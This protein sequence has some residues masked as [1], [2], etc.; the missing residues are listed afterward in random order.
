MSRFYIDYNHNAIYYTPAETRFIDTFG[1]TIGDI[2]RFYRVNMNGEN[3][4]LIYDQ[5]DGIK[6][7]VPPLDYDSGVPDGVFSSW[8][9]SSAN[10][11]VFGVVEGR[12]YLCGAGRDEYGFRTDG[13]LSRIFSIKTDGTDFKKIT[14]DTKFLPSDS[15]DGMAPHF[16]SC[17]I[18]NNK[19]YVIEGLKLYSMNLDGTGKKKLC[20]D[21]LPSGFYIIGDRLIYETCTLDFYDKNSYSLGSDWRSYAI[22]LDGTGRKLLF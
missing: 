1:G 14:A 4:T 7:T 20:D 11:G 21:D 3:K 6:T 17:M 13:G 19:I 8:P 12:L 5:R 22:K 10:G 18:A 16:T 9:T 15:Y 2:S